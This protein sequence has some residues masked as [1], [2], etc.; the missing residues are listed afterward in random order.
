MM[1]RIIA[2][3]LL[4]AA[5]LGLTTHT[6]L[7]VPVVAS[8]STYGVYLQG[9]E[10]EE[11]FF[12]AP[13]F[14]GAPEGAVW[15]NLN[16][17]LTES[18][19]VL[20]NGQS[21]ISI[22]LRA[23]GELFPVSNETAIY[24]IGIFGDGLDLLSMVSLYEARVSFFDSNNKLL[25][26]SGNLAELVYQNHPWDGFFPASDDAF[27]TEDIGGIGVMGINF[28]FLVG[29]KTNAVPEPG[30]FLL[31]ALGLLAMAA[32]RRQRQR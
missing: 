10:S 11:S 19:T 28:D 14:D 9:S 32:A 25:I 3:V 6:A 13:V 23:N 20:D 21:L 16:L 1:R 5:S 31:A 12:A 27:G 2:S 8:G 17:T 30:S 24:G 15:N 4:S 7:A 29:E 18:E 26:D 22:A